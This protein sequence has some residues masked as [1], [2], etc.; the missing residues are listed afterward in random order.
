MQDL[1][2]LLALDA[3]EVKF[4]EITDEYYL[5]EVGMMHQFKRYSIFRISIH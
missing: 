2:T 5:P 4:K 3:D 1:E